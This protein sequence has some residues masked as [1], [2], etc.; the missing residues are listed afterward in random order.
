MNDSTVIFEN[1][2]LHLH[3]SVDWSRINSEMTEQERRFVHGIVR[4]YKPKRLL[5]LGVSRGAGSVNLLNAI[6]DD[7]QAKL[8][9]IDVMDSFYGDG[10]IPVGS[11]VAKVFPD[12]KCG[13]WNLFTGVDV[14]V[15]IESLDEKFDF[16]VID[17][18]H[19]H[20]V[21]SLNFLC[22][23]PYLS[24]NAVVVF[25]DISLFYYQDC[26]RFALASRI[27]ISTLCGKKMFPATKET[28]F[29]SSSEPVNNISAVIVTPELIRNISNLFIAL[30]L[31]WE[32]YPAKDMFSIRSLLEKHYNEEQLSMFDEADR[33]NLAWFISG[34]TTFSSE[35]LAESIKSID[36]SVVFYGAGLNM[37]R[38]LNLY[39]QSEIKFDYPIW[40]I[41]AETIDLLETHRIVP[42][43]FKTRVSGTTAIITIS[44]KLTSD[45]VKSQLEQI[46]YSCVCGLKELFYETT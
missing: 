44:D 16:A 28:E 33:S 17:T 8:V 3:N 18:A 38:L 12:L 35:R 46:G 1:I 34:G 25:H 37:H 23:L 22:V 40:D 7:E 20:P 14:S 27:L 11:D 31:P 24:D 30:S 15:L 2:D 41:K 5:E 10:D 45:Y 29:I 13:K 19:T 26:K 36:E 42:P 32:M 6:S 4:H 43:D 21:E 39:R 9:S